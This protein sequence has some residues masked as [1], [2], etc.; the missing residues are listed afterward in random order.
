M[1]SVRAEHSG[2]VI[3]LVDVFSY[4]Q[5]VVSARVPLP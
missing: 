3:S 5:L 2:T 4:H 1:I